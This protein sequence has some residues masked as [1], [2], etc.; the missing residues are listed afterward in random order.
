MN[1]TYDDTCLHDL[2]HDTIQRW[3][4]GERPDAAALLT[5]HPALS[6][7]KSLAIDLIYE[8]YCLLNEKGDTLVPSTFCERFPHYRQS[9]SKMLEV[10]HALECATAEKS[11]PAKWPHVGDSFMGYE[12]IESLGRGSLARVFLARETAVGNRI[13]VVKVS[14]HGASEAQM[15]GKAVHPGIV[16][17]LS[18]TQDDV[19]GWTVICMPLLGTATGTDLLDAAFA[20]GQAPA[21]AETIS[22]VAG[23]FRPV[24]APR[25]R[26]PADARMWRCS[27]AD[28]IA[29]LGLLLAEG[30]QAAHEAGVM[31][32]D[33]KPSNVLLAWSGRPMLLDF[34]LSMDAGLLSNRV[35]GTLAYMAPELIESL[36]TDGSASARR[37]DPR[38]DLYSL[39]ALLYELLTGRLPCEPQNA[40]KLAPND[41]AAWLPSRRQPLAP[42][43]KLNPNVDAELEAIVLACLSPLPSMRP[44][45]A[46]EL[47]GALRKYLGWQHVALRVMRRRRRPLLAGA[48]CAA[49]LAISGGVY[50]GRLPPQEQRLY[51]RGLKQFDA[52]QYS[53]AERTLGKSIELTDR[54]EARFARGQALLQT[55]EYG[56][57]RAEFLALKDYDLALAY[58]LAGYC[59]IRLNNFVAAIND[60]GLAA[61]AGADNPVIWTNLGYCEFRLCSYQKAIQYL[62]QALALDPN[63]AIARY[64]RAVARYKL[65]LGENG[66]LSDRALDDIRAACDLEPDRADFHFY[67]ATLYALAME[68]DGTHRAAAVEHLKRALELGYPRQA[69]QGSGSAFQPLLKAL[70][71]ELLEGPPLPQAASPA[72]FFLSPETTAA[73]GDFSTR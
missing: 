67:A 58:S 62:D 54:P 16:P 29:R 70:P 27:Y 35:G 18:V 13:V 12:L 1:G 60:Y 50:V 21:S 41:F 43:R 44:A 66:A 5:R 45:S 14:R 8:E 19:T 11:P 49:A 26:V 68:R 20:S 4:D 36:A 63:V 2:V 9:L 61:Q 31:H 64:H 69:V 40:A 48:A 15:L 33:I 65:A 73:L 55:G 38:A 72:P 47:V 51:D 30:L 42:P 52:G 3:R 59:D 22:R 24:G 23:Q 39:G 17:I 10:H 34:N 57:A 7:H 32:R 37:F 56:P 46:P 71:P 6:R 28:G 25:E 53:A